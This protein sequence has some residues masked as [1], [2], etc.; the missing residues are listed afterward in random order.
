MVY[1][2]SC[3]LYSGVIVGDQ[4]GGCAGKLNVVPHD[5]WWVNNKRATG[6]PSAANEPMM[7]MVAAAK[8]DKKENERAWNSMLAYTM[9][10]A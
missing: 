7:E 4:I 2:L 1:Y 5:D 10:S 8:V 6:K 9:H 3:I